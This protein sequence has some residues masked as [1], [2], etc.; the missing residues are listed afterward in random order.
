MS[1]S[2]NN[3]TTITTNNNDEQNRSV[4]MFVCIAS[5]VKNMIGAGVVR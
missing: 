1:L 2:Q 5:M 4:G 3:P